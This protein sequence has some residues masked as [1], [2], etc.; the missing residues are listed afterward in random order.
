MDDINKKHSGTNK[1]NRQVQLI[2]IIRRI[3]YVSFVVGVGATMS[4]YKFPFKEMFW[5]ISITSLILAFSCTVMIFK[6]DYEIVD[7]VLYTIATIVLLVMNPHWLDVPAYLTNDYE[8]VK[9]VPTE[10]DYRSSYKAGKYLH[11]KVQNEELKLPTNV[12]ESHSDGWFII[13]YL[14][15]SK[16][17]MDFKILTKQET[18]EKLRKE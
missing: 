6:K 7:R 9:G 12:P 10:F 17:I 8:V 14:P 4:Q 15:N 18:E 16:F 1:K 2:K 5:I 13:R 11:V 3:W